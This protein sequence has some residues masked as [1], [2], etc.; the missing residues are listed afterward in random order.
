MKQFLVTLLFISS[1]TLHSQDTKKWSVG[2][3]A[4]N[5]RRSLEFQK[6]QVNILPG[7]CIKRQFSHFAIRA[8]YERIK[9]SLIY[10]RYA[11]NSQ[12]DITLRDEQMVRLGAEHRFK[13]LPRLQPFVAIDVLLL[14]TTS[15]HRYIGGSFA[16]AEDYYMSSNTIGLGIVP[17]AG[18]NWDLSD[19]FSLTAECRYLIYNNDEEV[20]YNH[21]LQRTTHTVNRNDNDSEFRPFG[22]FTISYKF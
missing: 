1:F 15:T 18:I 19:V 21:N 14:S 2:I 20:T 7:I 16:G 4:L 5:S 10:D 8:A 22:A 3:I 17:S 11:N 9:Q 6:K 12:V 13:I